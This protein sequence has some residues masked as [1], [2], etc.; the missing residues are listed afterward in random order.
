M[1]AEN[2]TTLLQ[3]SVPVSATFVGIVTGYCNNV[4]EFSPRIIL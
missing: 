3:Y 2:Y 4:V 1:C